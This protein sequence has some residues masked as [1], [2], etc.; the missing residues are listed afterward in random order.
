MKV[1]DA[2]FATIRIA[3]DHFHGEWNYI[4]SLNR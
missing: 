2:E 1:I 4:I 3:R